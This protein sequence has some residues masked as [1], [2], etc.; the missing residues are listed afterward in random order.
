MD[1]III[2]GEKMT[3]KQILVFSILM[4]N[5]EGIIGKAPSYIEE[6]LKICS[7]KNDYG[8]EGMLDDE[9]FEKFKQYQ[10]RWECVEMDKIK[11]GEK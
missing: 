10:R 11:K 1:K 3:L 4:Q 7:G 6:K 5:G 2:G 8:V 9:N